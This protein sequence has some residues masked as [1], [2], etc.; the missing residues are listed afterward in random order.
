MLPLWFSC[1]GYSKYTD[2]SSSLLYIIGG[3]DRRHTE[4]TTGRASTQNVQDVIFEI[5]EARCCRFVLVHFP[6]R[7]VKLLLRAIHLV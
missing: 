3:E 6:H 2:P 5:S 1:D 4:L 7:V